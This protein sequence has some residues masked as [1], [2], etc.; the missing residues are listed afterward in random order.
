MMKGACSDLS[1]TVGG[2]AVPLPQ[3]IV[4]FCA[5]G[6]LAAWRRYNRSVPANDCSGF[7]LPPMTFTIDIREKNGLR[8]LHFE[9]ESIQGAMRIARPWDLELEYTRVMMA[10]LLMRD[11]DNFPRNILLI[12]LGAGSLTKFLYRNCP[13][14][15]ITVVEIEPRV[16]AAAKQYF[17]LPDDPARLNIV[18]G[19]GVEF[20]TSAQQ[21]YDLILVDGFN[22]HG[23]PGELNSLPFYQACR[24]T[25]VQQGILVVNL[26]GLCRGAKGG[27]AH[28]EAAFERRALIFPACKSGNTIAFA[29]TGKPVD[30][31]LSVLKTRATMLRVRSGL[32]L[33]HTLVKLESEIALR[34]EEAELLAASG[35]DPTFTF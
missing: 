21:A 11:A 5:S 35:F 17:A 6:K 34:G 27:F 8:T 7:D 24:D 14:A 16:V 29:T 18:V 15:R 25:L 12:G 2:P 33:L 13:W 32:D 3:V 19:D 9:T 30:I 1:G 26:I 22:E 28:I 10:S 31:P 4:R 20:V 23:H